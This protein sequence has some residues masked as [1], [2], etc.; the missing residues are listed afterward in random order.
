MKNIYKA[1]CF[2]VLATAVFAC[3]NSD[4]STSVRDYDEVY[5]ED[6]AEIEE[7]MD[8]HFV[9]YDADFNT[10]FELIADGGTETPISNM[11]ELDSVFYMSNDVNYKIY[12]LKLREG[13]GESPTR[14]DSA[15]VAYKGIDPSDITVTFDQQIEPVWFQLED[16]ITGWGAIMPNFKTGTYSEEANGDITFD[17]FG[18][19]VMFVPS[20]LAY[21]N[22]AIGDVSSY[23]PLIFNFKLYDQKYKDHDSDGVL[24]KDEFGVDYNTDEVDA[25]D[26]DGDDLF[27]YEDPDDDNDGI[28]TLDEVNLDTYGYAVLPHPDCDNDG[29]PD[30]LDA[31]VCP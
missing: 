25:V 30:Y 31:D 24:S 10:T 21:F 12:Y 16:V 2:V 19:G 13:T 28:L 22:L 7:F 3:Q 8:T 18:A 1:L 17:N 27:D 15:F 20:G 9:T 14:L 23:S 11:P 5:L 29:I 4:D 6:I 26:T